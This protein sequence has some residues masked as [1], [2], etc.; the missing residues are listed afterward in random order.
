MVWAVRSEFFA[1]R[2]L[3]QALRLCCDLCDGRAAWATAWRPMPM[4]LS[5]ALRVVTWLDVQVNV[6]VKAMS[7]FL[8]AL[9]LSWGSSIH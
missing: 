1:R 5:A 7:V 6:I 9:L 8:I 3:L 2:Q 4:A